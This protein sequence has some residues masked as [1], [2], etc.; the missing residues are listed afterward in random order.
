MEKDQETANRKIEENKEESATISCKSPAED[1]TKTKIS[2]VN[3]SLPEVVNKK[4][5][6]DWAACLVFGGMDEERREM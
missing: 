2:R 6:M 4:A 1:S 3:A 5:V